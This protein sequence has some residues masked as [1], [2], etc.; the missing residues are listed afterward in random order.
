MMVLIPYSV[1]AHM[2]LLIYYPTLYQ[3]FLPNALI[4]HHVHLTRRSCSQ[5]H[6]PAQ[7]QKPT[8]NNQQHSFFVRQPR[9]QK[10]EKTRPPP[11]Q[12]EKEREI[13]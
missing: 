9:H 6:L 1:A 10:E 13:N 5:S 12:E 7:H 11:A 8:A 2:P 4:V 3:R